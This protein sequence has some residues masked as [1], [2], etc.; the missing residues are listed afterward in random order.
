MGTVSCS[1]GRRFESQ[2]LVAKI[3][4]FL[5]TKDENKQKR[6]GMAHLRTIQV[7]ARLLL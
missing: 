5:F 6:P 4:K 3:A 7:K 1:E 2:L